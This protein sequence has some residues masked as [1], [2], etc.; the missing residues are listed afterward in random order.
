[1]ISILLIILKIIGIA[2]LVI[3]GLILLLLLLVLLVPV[4]YRV[5][6]TYDDTF[7][8]KGNVSWL[9]HLVSIGFTVG[10]EVVTSIRILGI[11]LSAFMKLKKDGPKADAMDDSM[12]R[13]SNQSIKEE[14]DQKETIQ[15]TTMAKKPALE[16]SKT[17][18]DTPEKYADTTS[19]STEEDKQSFLQQIRNRIKNVW[20]KITSVVIHMINKVKSFIR[21]FIDKI[22]NIMQSIKDFKQN[23]REKKKNLKRYLRILQSD[24]TKAAFA[25]CKNKIFKMFKHIFPRKLHAEITYGFDDPATTGYSLALYGMLPVYI[26]KSIHLHPDFEKQIFKADFRVK[27]AIRAWTF[28]Y[29]ALGIFFDKN[30]RNLYH[31]VKK[32]IANEHK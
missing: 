19:D 6:G 1:M 11:P 3:L 31:I 4:K 5:K 24:N 23:L 21:A 29:H 25:L 13:D 10:E 27:G 14:E 30:C 28:L 17:V 12:K 22:K 2:I 32:E 15:D 8:C 16:E 7:Q 20:N 26:G 9:F 18:M